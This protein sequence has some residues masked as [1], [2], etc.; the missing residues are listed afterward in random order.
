MATRLIRMVTVTAT[1]TD[2]RRTSGNDEDADGNTSVMPARGRNKCPPFNKN[3]GTFVLVKWK[4]E[5]RRCGHWA[6]DRS[7][8]DDSDGNSGS[9]Q[10]K[11]PDHE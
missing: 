7:T 3:V 5:R 8:D 1:I 4:S 9:S 10:N 11:G 2:T 6:D